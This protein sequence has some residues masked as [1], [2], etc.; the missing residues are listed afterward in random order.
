MNE[1]INQL[2]GN[3]QLLI[4][5]VTIAAGVVYLLAS[6]VLGWFG[7]GHGDGDGAVDGHVDVDSADAGHSTVSIFSPKIIAIFCVGFGAGGAIA[8]AYGAGMTTSTLVA[9]A[10]GGSLGALMALML[11]GLHSQQSSS[12]LE[13][14]SSIGKVGSVTIEIPAG[15]TGEINL[16]VSGQY[17]T[18][19]AKAKDATVTIPR[20]RTVKVVSVS[21][22]TLIVELA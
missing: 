12:N 14:G 8:T 7:V 2:R 1:F 9:L 4:F 20:G 5:T 21:G 17:A 22:P 13:I 11:K 10:S 16:S 3:T 15:G 6:W 19:F 18:F